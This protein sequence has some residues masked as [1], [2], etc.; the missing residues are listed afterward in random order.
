MQH[1]SDRTGI[2]IL[3]L[4]PGLTETALLIDSPNKLLSRFMKAD[5]V[6]NL[7]QLPIQT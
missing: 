5:F 7:E 2:R 4:S 3:T 6:K 1:S